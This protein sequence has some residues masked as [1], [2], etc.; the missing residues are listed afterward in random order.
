[1]KK[2]EKPPVIKRGSSYARIMDELIA[3]KK[4][5]EFF[6]I[7][8]TEYPYWEGWKYKTKNW[9]IEPEKIWSCAKSHR[10]GGRRISFSDLTGFQFT[11]NSPVIIQQYLHEL[12]M[13]L[14]GNMQSDG[15]IPHEEKDRYLINSIM[16]EAI[17]SSQLEGAVTTRKVAKD[18]LEKERKPHTK[19]ELMIINNYEVM[20]WITLNKK[21][22][23]TP[24]VLLQIHSLITRDT[25]KDKK[26]E[27][28][29]RENDNV[30]VNE[31]ITGEVYYIPPSY[32][33]LPHLIE[34]L[35]DFANDEEKGQF[36]IHPISKAI[37]LHFLIG[38]IHPFSDGNGRTARAI[39]YWYLIRKG[40]WLIEY[41]SVSRIILQAKSQYAKAYLYTEYDDNDLTYFVIYNLK[42]LITALHDLKK[43]IHKKTQEKKH[44][45]SLIKNNGFNDRQIVLIKD[46][47]S[48]KDQYFTVKQVE[49]R[50]NV[51]NQTARN[52]LMYLIQ[53]GI[54]IQKKSGKKAQFFVADNYD[55]KLMLQ[56]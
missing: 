13:N 54:L 48:D 3:I 25:L 39:F 49:S 17:A 26:E 32:K 12:D 30:T 40:Y 1:M 55:K 2:P 28:N 50:F 41:M 53:K 45:L 4:F 46:I 6:E 16:E 22:K 56:K 38:Y 29:F 10:L 23:L 51:S 21:I 11:L 35:C 5:N 43:Y 19:S 34:N 42:A 27:G 24:E 20:R 37:I 14:G 18:M 9:N 52:D 36:F 8:E 33:H 44:T 15:I 7:D 47:L 31:D